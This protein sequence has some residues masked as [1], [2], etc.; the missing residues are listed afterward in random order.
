MAEAKLVGR[1]QEDNTVKSKAS[2]CVSV[3]AV[4]LRVRVW[5]TAASLSR[6]KHPDNRQL[7]EP[8]FISHKIL[9][10]NKNDLMDSNSPQPPGLHK[11]HSN[12]CSGWEN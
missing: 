10:K 7:N 3:Q 9:H 6:T 11:A 5:K 4:R 1:E 8:C 2:G 12:V